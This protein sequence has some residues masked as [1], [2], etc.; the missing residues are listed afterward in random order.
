MSRKLASS[1]KYS[2]K[3][4]TRELRQRFLIVCEGKKTEPNYFNG[5]RVNKKIVE[6]EAYGLGKDPTKIVEEAINR[7]DGDFDQIWCVFDRDSDSVTIQDFNNALKMIEDNN[8]NVAYSNPCFELWYLLHFAYRDTQISCKD[9]QK[10][11][12]EYLKYEYQ[13]NSDTMYEKLE[14][15]QPQAIRN[16]QRLLAEYNPPNPANDNP[17]TTVHLLVEELNQFIP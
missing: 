12:G 15:L 9:C 8:M 13:K 7:K 1:N 14:S 3:V 6:V 17:S 5:F 16:A 11:L 4:R 10:K 2:R